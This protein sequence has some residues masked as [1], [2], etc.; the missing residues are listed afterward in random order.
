[1]HRN[2][3]VGCL[4]LIIEVANLEIFQSAVTKAFAYIQHT[5]T[6]MCV[7][8]VNMFDAVVAESI[9]MIAAVFERVLGTSESSVSTLS[10]LERYN[11]PIL[12]NTCYPFIYFG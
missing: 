7:L 6:V 5:S 12:K 2:R 10:H 1:M 3:Y 9:L 8:L 4:N 11:L